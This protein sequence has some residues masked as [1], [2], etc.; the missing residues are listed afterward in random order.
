MSRMPEVWGED[1]LEFKPERFL[2]E[3]SDGRTRVKE[4]SQFKFHSFNAGPRMVSRRFIYN[5]PCCFN[6]PHSHAI[7]LL[8]LLSVSW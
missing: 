1:C 6:N 8:S 5:S 7:N 3:G 4:F 2:E